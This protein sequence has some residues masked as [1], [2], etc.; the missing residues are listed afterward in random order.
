MTTNVWLSQV[1]VRSHHLPF[2]TGDYVISAAHSG[3]DP[4]TFVETHRVAFSMGH[5]GVSRKS[6]NDSLQETP[7]QMHH[8]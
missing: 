5:K 6:I 1:S 4:N 7:S 8:S 3:S 2:L